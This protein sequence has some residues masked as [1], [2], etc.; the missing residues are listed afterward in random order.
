VRLRLTGTVSNTTGI[1]AMASTRIGGVRM[2]RRV[3]GA[4]GAYGQDSSV[5]EFGVGSAPG[6]FA[7]TVVWPSGIVQTV[8][9]VSPGQVVDVVEPGGEST[10]RSDRRG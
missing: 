3:D 9:G 8:D 4:S 6:P 1:G 10:H 2:S 7:F 5:L